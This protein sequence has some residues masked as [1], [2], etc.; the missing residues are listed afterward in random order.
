L[1][2]V[3]LRQRNQQQ[4]RKAAGAENMTQAPH[5]DFDYCEKLKPSG[6]RL[7]FDYDDQPKNKGIK[8]DWNE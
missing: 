6:I 4:V 7:D 8:L 2:T 3:F 1:A 5:L